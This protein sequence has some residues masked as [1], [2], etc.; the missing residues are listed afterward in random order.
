MKFYRRGHGRFLALPLLISAVAVGGTVGFSTASPASSH[1]A[2]TSGSPLAGAVTSTLYHQG[3][4]IS[5]PAAR[6]G[7]HIS[8]QA[9]IAVARA[10]PIAPY[11]GVG[12]MAL[13]RVTFYHMRPVVSGLFWVLSL[14]P[15]GNVPS[16]GLPGKQHRPVKV[17]YYFIV[18]NASTGHFFWAS[19]GG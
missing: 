14:R 13:A 8:E 15:S 5:K 2:A 12:Q 3:L 11:R 10:Q 17:K 7:P 19:I 9:A 16:N 4:R 6:I 18:I 1:S